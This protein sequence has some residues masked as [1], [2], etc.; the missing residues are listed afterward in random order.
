M[1]TLV[2]LRPGAATAGAGCPRV[3]LRCTVRSYVISNATP[4][5]GWLLRSGDVR[6][7]Q[8]RYLTKGRRP[9]RLLSQV[10]P[11]VRW[12]GLQ[13]TQRLAL[14]VRRTR[15]CRDGSQS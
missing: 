15:S 5:V 10:F 8:V 3:E 6:P 12:K 4:G 2:I 14:I 9:P 7:R 13:R 11:A 1:Y